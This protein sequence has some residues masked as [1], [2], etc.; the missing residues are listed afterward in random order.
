MGEGDQG[1]QERRLSLAQGSGWEGGKSAP[2]C[3]GCRTDQAQQG[4]GRLHWRRR[5]RPLQRGHLPLLGVEPMLISH[6]GMLV[7]M[8]AWILWLHYRT[9]CYVGSQERQTTSRE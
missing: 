7:H 6:S 9:K 5:G 2:S 1:I 4:A 3:S 8:Q